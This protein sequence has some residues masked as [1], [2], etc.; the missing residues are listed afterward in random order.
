MQE[1]IK[2]NQL[3]ELTNFIE[4]WFHK[5]DIEALKIVLSTYVAHEYISDNPVWLFVIGTPGTGKTSIATRALSYLP[6]TYEIGELTTT[7]FLSGHNDNGILTRLTRDNNGNGVIYFPDFT[8][9]LNKRYDVRNE[10][11]GQLRPIYDGKFT[12]EV[13]N[14]REV[15]SWKGKVSIVAAVTPAIEEFW[16]VNRNLGER[17]MNVRWN[18]QDGVETAAS[19]KKQIGNEKIIDDGFRERILAYVDI[20]TLSNVKID[21]E[22]DDGLPGLA[23]MV[24]KLR[25]SVKW[26]KINNRWK[27]IDVD[28]MEMPSR[29]MKSLVM[30]ARGAATLDRRKSIDSNDLELA[31]RVAKD[32]IPRNRWRV[33][34]P[35]LEDFHCEQSVPELR[36][37][38]KM[39]N[40]MLERTLEELQELETIMVTEGKQGFRWVTLSEDIK[41]WWDDTYPGDLKK[42]INNIGKD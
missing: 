34:K 24:A 38:T 19:S 35:I 36:K 21:Y 17:F 16:G 28:E 5:P 1:A 10:I 9:I 12:R 8:T 39:S 18:L 23:T 3:L 25:T 41:G 13:G 7:S 27:L 33:I 32:S 14:K 40:F 30:I 20:P 2:T 29:I 26:E 42:Q 22:E 37:K 15:L 31:K 11:I 6:N 4:K